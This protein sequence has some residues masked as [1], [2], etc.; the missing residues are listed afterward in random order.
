MYERATGLALFRFVE[1]APPLPAGRTR[2][3]IAASDFQETKNVSTLGHDVMPNTTH[4]A[5]R[6]HAR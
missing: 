4:A 5:R 1:E 3:E 2:R 6:D